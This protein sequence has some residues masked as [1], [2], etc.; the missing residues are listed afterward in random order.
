MKSLLKESGNVGMQTERERVLKGARRKSRARETLRAKRKAEEREVKL[1]RGHRNGVR[2]TQLL[3][4]EVKINLL[5]THIQQ[6]PLI[7]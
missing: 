1:G 4:H 2:K 5:N 6:P 7:S 3:S